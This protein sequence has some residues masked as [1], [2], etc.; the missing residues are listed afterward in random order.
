MLESPHII[1]S[2]H[3]L[4]DV[5]FGNAGNIYP[6]NLLCQLAPQS[7]PP[8]KRTF[9]KYAR[10][11]RKSQASFSKLRP[12]LLES[13][14]PTPNCRRCENSDLKSL[15]SPE[16][17]SRRTPHRHPRRFMQSRGDHARRSCKAIMRGDHA[18]RSCEAIISSG[19]TRDANASANDAAKKILPRRR[20]QTRRLA[21]L[22]EGVCNL[23]EQSGTQK[24][25][26]NR[27]QQTAAARGRLAVQARTARTTSPCTSVR[28][29]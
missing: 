26:Q 9:T 23:Y 19:G 29:K 1:P 13:T 7:L 12:V 27:P 22:R 11:Q 18:R 28:R 5:A 8:F 25:I 24:L 3:P 2:G 17:T 15:S 21:L 14:I 20:T 6:A 4:H 16:S 10:R